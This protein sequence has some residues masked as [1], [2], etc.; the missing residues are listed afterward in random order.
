MNNKEKNDEEKELKE[1]TK[2]VLTAIVNE[3]DETDHNL[4]KAVGIAMELAMKQLNISV[5]VSLTEKTTF[6]LHVQG[7]P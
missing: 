1:H 4:I 2:L 3:L 5:E 6:G 7:I